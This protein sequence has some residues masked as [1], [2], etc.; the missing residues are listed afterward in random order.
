MPLM[1][2]MEKLNERPEIKRVRKSEVRFAN[3]LII[4][5]SLTDLSEE[6]MSTE[7]RPSK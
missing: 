5:D 3:E 6:C 2:A 1:V 4:H 7:E